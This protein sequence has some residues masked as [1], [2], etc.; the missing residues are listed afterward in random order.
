MAERTRGHHNL[1]ALTL[2]LASAVDLILNYTYF[3]V[4]FPAFTRSTAASLLS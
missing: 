2:R 1:F 4:Y 3:D